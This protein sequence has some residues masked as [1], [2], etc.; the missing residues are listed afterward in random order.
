MLPRFFFCFVLSKHRQNIKFS[1]QKQFSENTI[2]CFQKLFSKIVLKKQEPHRPLGLVWF[3][4]FF[5]I[6]KKH[7]KH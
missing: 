7:I 4:V 1:D 6:I 3:I 5:L 2:W